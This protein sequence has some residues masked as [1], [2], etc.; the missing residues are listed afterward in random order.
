MEINK[1]EERTSTVAVKT[2]NECDVCKKFKPRKEKNVPEGWHYFCAN[3]QDSDN[4]NFVWYEVCSPQCYIEKISEL[5]ISL[6]NRSE[7][8][9]DEMSLRFSDRL[10]KHLNCNSDMNPHNF[11]FCKYLLPNMYC[12]KRNKYCSC[13]NGGPCFLSI[14]EVRSVKKNEY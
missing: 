2:G 3:H 8:E 10:V 11:K 6:G 4:D 13:A 14:E 12:D 5:I 7:P 9:I 1:N